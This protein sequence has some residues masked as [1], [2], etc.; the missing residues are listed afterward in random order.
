MKSQCS[1]LM[2]F[3]FRKHLFFPVR[4]ESESESYIAL[5]WVHKES[6]LMFTLGSDQDQR[7]NFSSL[8]VN[9]AGVGFVFY[10]YFSCSRTPVCWNTLYLHSSRVRQLAA[11]CLIL[12]V[13]KYQMHARNYICFQQT[14]IV[15]LT[16]FWTSQYST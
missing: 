12:H 13:Q 3:S 10:L 4:I 7:I 2:L 8:N 14:P 16:V 5:G 9:K 6:H 11:F 15:K 1:V